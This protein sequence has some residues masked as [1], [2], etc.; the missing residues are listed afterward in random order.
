[1]NVNFT[2]EIFTTQKYGGISR[3]FVELALAISASKDVRV[4]FRAPIYV[5]EYLRQNRRA[6]KHKGL[7]LPRTFRGIYA[8]SRLIAGSMPDLT[9]CKPSDVY[10][11]T[12]FGYDLLRRAKG[13]KTATFYDMIYERFSPNEDHTRVKKLTLE[14]CDHCIAISHATKRDMVEY[15]KASPEKISVVHLAANL[16]KP[17]ETAR[18]RSALG[19]SNQPI[20]LW[21]GPR[22][23]Y[24]NFDGFLRGYAASDISSAKPRIVCAGGPIPKA[25]EKESWNA[26]GVDPNQIVHLL[27]TDA[28]LAYLYQ[29]SCFLAYLSLYEGFGM[30]PLEAMGYGCP[31]LA[32]DAGSIPEVVGDAAIL[33]DPSSTD[34]IS[35]GIGRIL[36]STTRQKELAE[37]GF[38]RAS[39]FSWQKCADE[40]WNIYNS[41]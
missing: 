8:L 36:D 22:S 15:L 25:R 26:L 16:C 40:T 12:Y 39:H 38:T 2:G 13:R 14:A 24:K 19:S 29:E 27:P 21:V 3:Y 17:I 32:S 30:P 11:E 35:D 31:V 18:V 7:Y 6:L 23:W 10:H 20:I 9:S 37:L 28:E 5:N 1:M 4:R 33:V 34:S 41:L